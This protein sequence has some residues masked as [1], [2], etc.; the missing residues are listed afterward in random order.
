[1]ATI[2]YGALLRVNGKFINYNKDF[3]QKLFIRK[4]IFLNIRSMYIAENYKKD[5]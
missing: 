3:F 2:D 5:Q 1:M 4:V